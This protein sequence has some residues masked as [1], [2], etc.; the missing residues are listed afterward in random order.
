MAVLTKPKI[1]NALRKRLQEALRHAE[2]AAAYLRK[3]TVEL[4]LHSQGTTTTEY[5]ALST[6]ELRKSPHTKFCQATHLCPV[7]KEVGSDMAGLS[8]CIQHL[9][10]LLEP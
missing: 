10:D 8:F 9:K 5:A 1:S 2:R 4:C 3:P 6:P 7:E